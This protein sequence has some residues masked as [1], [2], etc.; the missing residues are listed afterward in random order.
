MEYFRDNFRIT[1]DKGQMDIDAILRL[2]HTTYWAPNRSKAL[3]EACMRSSLCYGLFDGNEQIGYARVISDYA[4]FAYLCDVI[5]A[6]P[7]QH[8]GLGKWLMECILEHPQ[9]QGMRRWLLSTRDAKGFYA[10]FGFTPLS[11]PEKFM[12]IFRPEGSETRFSPD[13]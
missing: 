13:D 5:I 1:T 9:L 6:E 11:A 2:L 7:Y 8:R 3:Q 10:Q 4:T 12:E